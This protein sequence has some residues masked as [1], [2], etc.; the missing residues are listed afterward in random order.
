M[1]TLTDEGGPAKEKSLLDEFAG[2]ALIG[3]LAHGTYSSNKQILCE[4][5]W[6]IGEMMLATKPK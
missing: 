3:L 5:A 1:K 2:E 6:K 4:E